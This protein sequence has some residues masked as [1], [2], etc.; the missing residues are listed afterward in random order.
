MGTKTTN[1][2]KAIMAR[3]LS[4]S[5]LVDRVGFLPRE[6]V[7]E[8]EGYSLEPRVAVAGEDFI[9]APWPTHYTLE[10]SLKDYAREHAQPR[11][12][13]LNRVGIAA[14][15][16]MTA[17]CP[18]MDISTEGKLRREHGRTVVD[19]MLSRKMKPASARRNM[20]IGIAA[21]NHAKKEERIKTVPKFQMPDQS[22][23]RIRWLTREEHRALM[24]APK[25]ERIRKF[26]TVAF[27]T[28]ARS[29][30]IEELRWS[31]VNMRER[32]IDF[33]VPGVVYRNK[34]RAVVPISDSLGQHLERFYA[35]RESDFVIGLG[36]RGKCS[37]TY[38]PCKEDLAQIGITEYGVARHVARHTVASWLLQGDPERGIPPASIYDVA[39]LLGDK[40][41]M[42]ERTYAHVM[43][44]QL[45][46]ATAVLP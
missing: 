26:W 23:P 1:L 34:R 25:P 22:S 41:S 40:V 14:R 15:D 37:C 17:L 20:A 16:W 5:E 4:Y 33:R 36:E 44:Q 28:G 13:C 18:Q 43:P 24:E 12:V 46:R 11:G 27:A 10:R 19:Y 35:T 7:I 8:L 29:R 32:T 38:I 31:Q 42:I 21:L 39:Q 45:L 6:P 2:V 30:A 3:S 9:Q